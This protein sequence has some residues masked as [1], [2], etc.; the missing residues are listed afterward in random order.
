MEDAD[1]K[2][3]YRQ[4]SKEREASSVAATAVA[5]KATKSGK[6]GQASKKSAKPAQTDRSQ[7][8]DRMLGAVNTAPAPSEMFSGFLDAPVLPFSTRS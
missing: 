4:R 2:A 3:G 8:E 7:I 6:S 1:A 5:R